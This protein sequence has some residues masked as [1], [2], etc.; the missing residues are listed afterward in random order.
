GGE[1]RLRRTAALAQAPD[2]FQALVRGNAA[3]DDEQ[4]SFALKAHW[5]TKT[6]SFRGVYSE[7]RKESVVHG[8]SP[9]R[10]HFM[11]RLIGIS[12]GGSA[13]RGSRGDREKRDPNRGRRCRRSP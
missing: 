11:G 3:A 7:S 4:D 12:P 2:K 10:A 9:K 13:G 1:N 6:R 5:N 8:N